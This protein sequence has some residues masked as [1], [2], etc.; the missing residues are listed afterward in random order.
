[1]IMSLMVIYLL[2]KQNQYGRNYCEECGRNVEQSTKHWPCY[3][4]ALEDN[5]ENQLYRTYCTRI[6]PLSLTVRIVKYI[7]VQSMIIIA[8]A[9]NFLVMLC[10]LGRGR[11]TEEE[12]KEIILRYNKYLSYVVDMLLITIIIILTI[13]LI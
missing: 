2:L 10:S 11:K 8:L 6:D 1:M 12:I 13:K 7:I 9:I 4:D 3:G 5:V